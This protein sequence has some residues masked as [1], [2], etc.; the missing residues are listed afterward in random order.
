MSEK[1]VLGSLSADGRRTTMMIGKTEEIQV[2]LVVEPKRTGRSRRR[3]MTIMTMLTNAVNVVATA[4]CPMT[5]LNDASPLLLAVALLSR[6]SR[7][8]AERRA[9]GAE[10]SANSR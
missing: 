10:V 4:A 2:R 1:Q 3:M 9:I 5:L 8:A 6:R 7:V